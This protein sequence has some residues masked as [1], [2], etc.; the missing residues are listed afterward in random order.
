[1]VVKLQHVTKSPGRLIKNTDLKNIQIAGLL[2]QRFQVS[3][4]ELGSYKDLHFR[5]FPGDAATAAP[6]VRSTALVCVSIFT[7]PA[8]SFS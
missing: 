7:H 3:R 2:S 6:I 8:L 5:E 1:M 4:S